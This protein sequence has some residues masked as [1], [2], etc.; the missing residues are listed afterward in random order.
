M[1]FGFSHNPAPCPQK[2][3]LTFADR[4]GAFFSPFHAF[5]NP[6]RLYAK[7]FVLLNTPIR[8]PHK[9]HQ[10]CGLAIQDITNL[11][12]RIHGQM[13]HRTYADSGHRRRAD[14]CL[15]RKFL[16]GHTT[17]RKHHFDFELY[18]RF[19]PLPFGVLYHAFRSKSIRNPK[20]NFV[21][22]KRNYEIRIDKLRFS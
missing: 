21:F 9:L 13:L 8:F 15:F 11:F 5:W 20:N 1:R 17:H 22:R 3:E 6:P 18:H 14:T 7:A 19:S 12:Q 2:G 4:N 10:V 16:L